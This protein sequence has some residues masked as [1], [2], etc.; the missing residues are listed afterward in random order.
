MDCGKMITRFEGSGGRAAIEE[1]LLQQRIVLGNDALATQLAE[2]GTP[3]AVAM[4]D[5]IINQGAH[6]SDVFS[7]SQVSF[8]SKYMAAK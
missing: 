5:T 1:A 6:D 8:R 7:S 3:M 4:G 2:V